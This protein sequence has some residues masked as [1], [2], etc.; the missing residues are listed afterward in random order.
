MRTLKIKSF[1]DFWKQAR[2]L[3]ARK[4]ALLLAGKWLYDAGFQPG[5]E[6]KVMVQ[7]GRIVIEL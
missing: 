6:V 3:M 7:P 1:G 5:T 2:G 4:S